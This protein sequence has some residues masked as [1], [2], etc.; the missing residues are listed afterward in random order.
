MRQVSI[1]KAAVVA[2]LGVATALTPMVSVPAEA[3]SGYACRDNNMSPDPSDSGGRDAEGWWGQYSCDTWHFK[4][5]FQAYDEIAWTME[6]GALN[7]VV[8]VAVWNKS[9]T[10]IVD[11]DTLE[12]KREYQLGYPD[13]SGNIPE[14]RKVN[15]RM[16]VGAP[17]YEC[18][19]WAS[20][21]S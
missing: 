19:G 17:Y 1:R 3:Q 2:T 5:R 16:C 15:I 21:V 11:R 9:G 14:G 8:E 20:G 18:T 6:S 7:P 13:G 10:E 12:G 4:V